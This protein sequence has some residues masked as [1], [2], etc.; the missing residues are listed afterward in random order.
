MSRFGLPSNRSK[1]PLPVL[2]AVDDALDQRRR[3]LRC[4]ARKP[5]SVSPRFPRPSAPRIAMLSPLQAPHAI[6]SSV[7]LVSIRSSKA[8][9]GW[10]F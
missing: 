3:L 6:H 5:G 1:P 2:L 4:S 8:M 7:G 9:T 10:A